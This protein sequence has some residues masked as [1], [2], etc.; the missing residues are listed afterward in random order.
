MHRVWTPGF[1]RQNLFG[2][3]LDYLSFYMLAFIAMMRAVGPGDLVVAKTDPPLISIIAAA[4][5]RFKHATLINWLQDLFPEVA[6]ALGV[7]PISL[8]FSPLRAARDW[9]LRRAALNVVLGYR[10]RD[11]VVA[12]GVPSGRVAIVPNWHVGLPPDVDWR[13]QNPLRAEWGLREKF[14]VAYSGN[15]GR[16]HDSQTLFET[17][18]RLANDENIHFLL[19]G[20]G[21]K[22]AVLKK[23]VS[24]LG[25]KNVTFKPYQPIERLPDSLG[26]A[27]VHVVTLLPQLEGLIVPSKFY[28]IIAAGR[29][30]VFVGEER[31]E[32]GSI[33]RETSC[34]AVVAPGRAEELAE[35]LG[36]LAKDPE[37]A[38]QLGE[39]AR[40]LHKERYDKQ[41][42]FERW[43]TLLRQTAV[44]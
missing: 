12:R 42:T 1:S 4:V 7:R 32:L 6:Q 37:A 33:I 3:A 14:V 30:C 43:K 35:F 22:Y 8:L 26:V 21:A 23:E 10:M 9:S 24:R 34:G 29:P 39:N 41:V 18:L 28:G 40:A 20:G 19:I 16:A 5:A 13:D 2:R 38:A 11:L 44:P 17:M 25:L 31:G 27:D 15:L 36:D